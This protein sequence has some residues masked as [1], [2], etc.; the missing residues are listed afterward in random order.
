MND[1]GTPDFTIQRL[2]AN[3]ADSVIRMQAASGN[4]VLGSISGVE[5]FTPFALNAEAPING[6]ETVWN[7]TMN[8]G[9]LTLAWA[10]A[11]GNWAAGATDKYLGLKFDISGATHYGWLRLDTEA[12]ATSFIVK[13]YAYNTVADEGLAAGEGVTTI[14]PPTLADISVGNITIEGAEILLTPDADGTVY[15]V[16]VETTATAPIAAEIVAGTGTGGA[17][18]IFD[19]NTSVNQAAPATLTATGLAEDTEYT[20]YLVL[21]DGVSKTLSTIYDVNFTT[22]ISAINDINSGISIFPNPTDGI[23][24]IQTNSNNVI[25]VLDVT[26]KEV[27]QTTEDVIDLSQFGSGMY[28][29]KINTGKTVITKRII[30]K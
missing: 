10:S 9:S 8:G 27:M 20:A 13:D 14:V 22:L 12:G 5:F 6:T 11:Y 2:F 21:D 26:G 16:V 3:S 30:V 24:K 19:G 23:I 25:S 18:A 1:D 29:L 17:T 28:I 4:E 7:G 15:C